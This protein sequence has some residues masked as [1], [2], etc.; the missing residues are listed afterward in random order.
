MFILR[1][2]KKGIIPGTA[3][4]RQKLV[5][6]ANGMGIKTTGAFQ[7]SQANNLPEALLTRNGV[8]A[9]KYTL[10]STDPSVTPED[11]ALT[12]TP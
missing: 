8:K 12:F 7:I 10:I 4:E 2:V 1:D 11:L 9:G 5:P 3:E 6:T